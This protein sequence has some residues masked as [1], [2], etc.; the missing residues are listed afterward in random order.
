MSRRLLISYAGGVERR[1]HLVYA[2]METTTAP[3]PLKAGQQVETSATVGEWLDVQST[4]GDLFE[5]IVVEAGNDLQVHYIVLPPADALPP[6]VG[7]PLQPR[8]MAWITGLQSQPELN[9]EEVIL[10]WR[11]SGRDGLDRWAVRLIDGART[12]LLV[13]PANLV[14]LKQHVASKEAVLA[15]EARELLGAADAAACL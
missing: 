15:A 2:Q 12:Q 7:D 3:Y 1:V 13:R 14:L 11:T 9:H 5:R 4:K 10:L 6:N 8:Q